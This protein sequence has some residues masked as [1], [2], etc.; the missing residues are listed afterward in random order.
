M[1]DTD[2]NIFYIDFYNIF[3][4][5]RIFKLDEIFLDLNSLKSVI[6]SM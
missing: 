3:V 5:N 1:E 4:N 6:I 2:K